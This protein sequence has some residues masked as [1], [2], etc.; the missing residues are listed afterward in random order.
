MGKMK[1][2]KEIM[3]FGWIKS[4]PVKGQ[5]F[6]CLDF[7]QKWQEHSPTHNPTKLPKS[8]LGLRQ[9]IAFFFCCRKKTKKGIP[10]I[11]D[12]LDS[13]KS[14][15]CVKLNVLLP[16]LQGLLKNK[17]H[18]NIKNILTLNLKILSNIGHCFV[19]NIKN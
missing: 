18:Q 15:G 16:Y 2:F 13:A 1:L 12:I 17:W 9:N 11:N 5:D 10:F 7:C 14:E 8:F 3:L 19:F 4:T 6:F